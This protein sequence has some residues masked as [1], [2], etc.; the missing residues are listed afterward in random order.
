[1]D[2]VLATVQ[3]PA[4]VEGTRQVN[5]SASLPKI[6]VTT[7]G[8]GVCSHVGSRLLAEV[9]AAA[10]LPEAL[11]DAVGGR[12]QRRSAHR[13]GRVLTDLAVLLA[14][15]GQSIT[16][17][18][19]LRDQPGLFGSVA[20]TATAWRGPASLRPARGGAVGRRRGGGWG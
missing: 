15:G 12:R 17:L 3:N 20:S 11:D 9:A 13:P 7:G 1:M 14:D 16:D 8:Q 5:S 10:G 6:S 19:V 4:R 18:A 2:S